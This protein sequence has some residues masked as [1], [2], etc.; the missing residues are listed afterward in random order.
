MNLWNSIR[1]AAAIAGIALVA[2]VATA[3]DAG[4]V[5][6]DLGHYFPIRTALAG[7]KT[8]GVKDHANELAKSSDKATAKAAEAVAGAKDLKAARKAF[9]DLSKALIAAV[10]K[11]TKAGTDIGAVYVF[12]CPMAKPYGRWMQAEAELGN[13]YYGSQMF[14][15]GRQIAALG[16]AAGEKKD[17]EKQG[18]HEGHEGHGGH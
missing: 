12:E 7:D 10:E 9:G 6:G 5:K 13:P 1:S 16:S 3:D 11:A 14:T 15:C 8:E 2:S 17:G 4:T 18:G